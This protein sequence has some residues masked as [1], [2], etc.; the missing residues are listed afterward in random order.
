MSLDLQPRTGKAQENTVGF[1]VGIFALLLEY[2][3][4]CVRR[5][6]LDGEKSLNHTVRYWF[7]L[8]ILRYCTV[9]IHQVQSQSVVKQSALQRGY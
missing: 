5:S 1:C 8:G 4:V 6:S 3:F 7:Q 9:P 2:T